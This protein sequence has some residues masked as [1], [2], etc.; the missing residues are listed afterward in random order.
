[1]T[2]IVRVATG[3]ITSMEFIISALIL[4]VSNSITGMGGAKI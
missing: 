2:M 3:A 4:I 1:M